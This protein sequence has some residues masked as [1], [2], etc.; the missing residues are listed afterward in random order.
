MQDITVNTEVEQK[1]ENLLLPGLIL[2]FPIVHTLKEDQPL[3]LLLNLLF[4]H[5]NHSEP[6]YKS[7][8]I[9]LLDVV[10][11]FNQLNVNILLPGRTP[12][13]RID[14]FRNVRNA[15]CSHSFSPGKSANH[16]WVQTLVQSYHI[17]VQIFKDVR[18]FSH[19]QIAEAVGQVLMTID[20]IDFGINE[21]RIYLC[22]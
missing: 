20:A 9:N 12:G 11:A 3:R 2:F 18:T 7:Q 5:F 15:A 13:H 1:K 19:F 10:A 4:Y 14:H 21:R 17:R 22:W 8:R 6:T 16:I